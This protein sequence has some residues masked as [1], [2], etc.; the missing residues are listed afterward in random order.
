MGPLPLPGKKP[1]NDICDRRFALGL[2]Q[3]EQETEETGVH[4]VGEAVR[5]RPHSHDIQHGRLVRSGVD[6]SEPLHVLHQTVEGSERCP[7]QFRIIVIGTV[8][9][10][11]QSEQ[12]W[13]GHGEID[14]T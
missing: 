1:A 4:E 12:L 11:H 3:A 9:G 13:I 5:D 8:G 10:K 2:G 14:V 6:A 7:S